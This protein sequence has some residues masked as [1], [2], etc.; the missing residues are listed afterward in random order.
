[1]AG[2]QKIGKENPKFVDRMGEKH[3]TTEGYWIEIIE[4]FN[5]TNCTVKFENSYTVTKVGYSNILRGNIKNPYH[6]SVYKIGYFGVG[7]YNAMQ[8]RKVDKIYDTW[9]GVLR[10]CYDKNFLDKRPTYKG[11]SVIEEWFNFQVFAEWFEENYKNYMQGWHL[12]K[13]ILVKGNKIYSPETCC[14]VPP[15]INGLFVN[16]KNGRGVHPIGVSKHK[17]Q[18]K[19]QTRLFKNGEEITLGYFNT[20]EEAF[21]AYKIAKEDYI[22]EVADKWKPYITPQTH[23]AMYNYQVEI[24]D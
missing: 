1:M 7:K 15:E 19:F 11:C 13:D 4:Y 6:L 10:R 16:R 5:R 9:K 22:K 3:L 17:K 14:F 21:Q 23:Q 24:T 18:N 8:D 20:P 2:I 12:D